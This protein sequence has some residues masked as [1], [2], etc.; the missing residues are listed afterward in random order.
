MSAKLWPST[1][2]AP[3]LLRQRTKAHSRMSRRY[4]LSYKPRRTGSQASSSLW[5][6]TPSVT[7]QPVAGG[8]RLTPISWMS[9]TSDADLE[10][11]APSL[12][13]RYP[14]SQVLRA[15]PPPQAARPVPRGRPV[16]DHAPPRR[17]GFPCCV[18]SPFADMPSSI[19]PAARWALIARGMDYSSLPCTQRLRPSPYTRKVGDQALDFS[20]PAQR[21]LAI[22]ACR[23]A[24]SPKLTLPVSKAPTVSLPPRVASIATGWSDPVAGWDSHPLKINTFFTAH[25]YGVPRTVAPKSRNCE[26]TTFQRGR[27]IPSHRAR[28]CRRG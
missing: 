13:R 1:P 16:E 22:T 4:N 14:A 9:V 2:G 19:L 11:R 10:P 25:E 28:R 21:S 8:S 18:G 23:L 6:A 12:H 3:R 24:E 17:M 20:R 7:S 26:L 15:S 27:H 5:C